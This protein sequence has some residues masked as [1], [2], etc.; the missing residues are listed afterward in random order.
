MMSAVGVAAST[1][2]IIARVRGVTV[3]VGPAR[4]APFVQTPNSRTPCAA[5]LAISTLHAA[6]SS[7]SPPCAIR[8]VGCG[9]TAMETGRLTTCKLTGPP[10]TPNAAEQKATGN[11]RR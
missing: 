11:T 6:R 1:R 8:V 3:T 5:A 4:S 9:K 2:L 7:S 10:S